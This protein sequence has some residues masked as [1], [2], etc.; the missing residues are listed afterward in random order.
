MP[1]ASWRPMTPVDMDDVERIAEIVHPGFPEA[2][3]VLAEKL[4]LHPGGCF[5][6]QSSANGSAIGYLLSH[7][8]RSA[9]APELDTLIGTLPEPEV[10][11]IHDIALLP[12]ARGLRAG[13]AA[14]RLVEAHTRELGLGTVAL[15]AVNSSGG[16]WEKQGFVASDDPRWASKLASYGSDAMYMTRVV[17]R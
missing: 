3:D 1:E 8:W 12:A 2:G 11:Y 9:D 6:L 5:I 14:A 13:E 7:P 10:Y 16:F 17:C 4:A 15:V